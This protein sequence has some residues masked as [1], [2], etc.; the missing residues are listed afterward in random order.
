MENQIE[1]MRALADALQVRLATAEAALGSCQK[2]CA[3]MEEISDATELDTL[4]ALLGAQIDAVG[5][6]DGYSINLLD[7]AGE[8][9]VCE[10]IRLP[11]EFSG[12]EASYLKF[13]FP[14]AVND[15]NVECW[16]RRQPVF[17]DRENLARF[18]GDT[19]LRF[20]R[21]LI[22]SLVI[23][24]IG[25]GQEKMLGTLMLFRRQG[26]VTEESAL[27]VR[28]LLGLFERQLKLVLYFHR[29][30]EGAADAQTVMREQQR[31]VHF[32]SEVNTL[33]S[34]EQICDMLA[35]EFLQRFPFDLVGLLMREP[36]G[37]VAKKFAVR[38]EHHREIGERLE[39][40]FRQAPYK[41]DSA[42]GASVSCFLQ[43]K[44]MVFRDVGELMRLP[45]SGKDRLALEMMRTTRS[46]LIAPVRRSGRQ[47]GVIWLASLEQP[48]D[49][50][51]SQLKLIELLCSFIGT[52][53]ANAELYSLVQEQKREIEVL[54]GS[55]EQKVEE[56]RDQ[57]NRDKL[58]GLYNFGCFVEEL[59]RRMHEYRR[60]V[61]PSQLS[62]I[63]LDVDHFKKI[64]DAYG[65]QAGNL[66]LQGVAQRIALVARKMDIACRFGGEEFA[67]ILPKCDAEGA[68]VVAERLR[69]DVERKP[70]QLEDEGVWVTV[71]IGCSQYRLGEDVSTFVERAD[72]ALYRAKHNGRNRVDVLLAGD[73]DTLL[74]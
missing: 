74:A 36:A 10:K 8:N 39:A 30:H 15:A 3:L 44:S 2:E 1:E 56:L 5:Q 24:P 34:S 29:L 26:L 72:Q 14:L 19:R 52:V 49:L 9:L 63:I 28:N 62:L 66:V 57:A 51:E 65:H 27:E 41:L 22:Q 35:R 43:N 67:I 64:N 42:E 47:V 32:V 61:A 33:T 37:L 23:L 53:L 46:F 48:V 73:E 40:Y 21:W 38:Q 11:A 55:L 54:N 13:P 69:A 60:L 70:F 25:V 17:V 45:M 18:H 50:S 68:R 59:D 71:S 58:T 20:E 6:F 12:I 7:A 16:Q 4:L 31:F